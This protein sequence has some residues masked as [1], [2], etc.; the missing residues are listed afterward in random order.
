MKVAGGDIGDS[1]E[2]ITGL[3]DLWLDVCSGFL[4]S[5]SLVHLLHPL[6]RT[7]HAGCGTSLSLM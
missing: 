1:Q 3:A 7:R 4:P 6:L 5:D 2:W